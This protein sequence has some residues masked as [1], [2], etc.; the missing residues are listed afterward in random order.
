[1]ARHSI[2]TR[3]RAARVV[4]VGLEKSGVGVLVE[5]V[6]VESGR[7]LYNSASD[8]GCPGACGIVRGEGFL[9]R[10]LRDLG[11]SVPDRFVAA[12]LAEQQGGD[13][14]HGWY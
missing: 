9:R 8:P 10:R 12:A 11:V 4:T 13:R 3:D 5:V 14:D 7:E 1:M 6:C 2:H